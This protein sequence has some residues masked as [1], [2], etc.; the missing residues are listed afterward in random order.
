[1]GAVAASGGVAMGGHVAAARQ[2][3]RGVTV[4]CVW[5]IEMVGDDER[6]DGARGVAAG[7]K[8]ES[9]R[10]IREVELQMT[11]SGAEIM[12]RSLAARR[13]RQY[14][15]DE[16]GAPEGGGAC[17]GRYCDDAE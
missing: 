9:E 13:R 11:S 1:M 12:F 16:E 14:C 7:G 4:A 10:E 15:E 2:G 8:E 3:F 6:A 5:R 17:K